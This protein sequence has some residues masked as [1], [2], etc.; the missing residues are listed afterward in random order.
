MIE[1]GKGRIAP[2]AV[3]SVKGMSWV[4]PR[5]RVTIDPET[6][7]IIQDIYIKVVEEGA[8]GKLYNRVV[9]TFPQVKDP[10]KEA[11]RKR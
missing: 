10:W 3:D 4:S 7:D 5:G 11:R 6:R 1:N 2:D 8:G 9:E